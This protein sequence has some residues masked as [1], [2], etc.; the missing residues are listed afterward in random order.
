ME[1]PD[2]SL[3]PRRDGAGDAAARAG[4][5]NPAPEERATDHA[6]GASPGL[7]ALAAARAAAAGALV[8]RVLDG[9]SDLAPVDD[10]E[11]RWG[12]LNPPA[13]AW[14][15]LLGKEVERLLG[16]VLWEEFPE[17]CGGPLHR[18][19]LQVVAEQ[20]ELAVETSEPRLGREFETRIIPLPGGAVSLT[21]DITARRRATDL[22]EQTAWR[23]D[24][25]MDLARLATWSVDLR[26]GAGAQD[27][28]MRALFGLAADDLRPIPAQWAS[29]VHVD[30]ADRVRAALEAAIAGASAAERRFTVGYRVVHPDGT[31][32]HI[33]SAGQVLLDGAR[34]PVLVTGVARDVTTEVEAREALA[35]SA[36]ELQEVLSAQSFL[37]RVGE[38]LGQSLEPERT[39]ETVARLAV[40]GIA[41]YCVL[42]V[43]E[44]SGEIRRVATAHADPG[45]D[46]P[47]RA[48][49]KFPPPH[50]R[51]NFILDVLATGRPA[52]AEFRMEAAR[53]ISE[54][55]EFL[56]LIE[57]LAPRSYCCVPMIARG[58]TLGSLLLVRVHGSARPDFGAADVTLAQEMARRAA[59]ALDNARLFRAEQAARAEAEEA[60]RSKTE[61]LAMMSHELRTPLNAIA[62]YAQLIELGVHGPVNDGVL[63]SVARIQRSQRHLLGLIDEL[64]SFARLEAGRLEFDIQDVPVDE[65]CR[66][67]EPLIAPQLDEKG[68]EYRREPGPGGLTVR[69]DRDK[70]RQILLNLLSNAVK[71]TDPGGRITVWAEADGPVARLRVRDTG[72]GIP[73]E[74]QAD[75]F[76]PFYQVDSSLTRPRQ[77]TGLGLAIARRLAR[78]MR[79][80]VTVESQPGAG[81]TFTV[82]LRRGG[83]GEG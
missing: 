43:L 13:R 12:Y 78:E 77:G 67:V 14:V 81:S 83:W 65:L 27:E 17:L 10:A 71:F 28:R 19:A 21:R 44:E 36:A 32:H 40:E 72:I 3:D 4:A 79:G 30:D 15:E 55:P 39:L 26:T 60:N 49:E 11:W 64:L 53:S 59:L 62:G 50:D 70:L 8:R 18:V 57:R 52:V 75:I 20:R 47:L 58:R 61:F 37:A 74:K 16:R 35:R 34:R 76:E 63:A 24:L 51:P 23:L 80:D 73:P 82:W 38:A 68:I 54:D 48:L 31:I 25:A 46:A 9:L 45:F 6:R 7:A 2:I 5:P 42:D 33:E 1:F 56:R 66:A 41:D 29:R 69:A 22:L